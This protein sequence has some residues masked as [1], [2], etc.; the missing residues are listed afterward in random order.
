MT[1]VLKPFKY[2]MINTYIKLSFEN[3]QGAVQQVELPV[4]GLVAP[5]HKLVA[6]FKGNNFYELAREASLNAGLYPFLPAEPL[7][8]INLSEDLILEK[9]DGKNSNLK[10]TVNLKN[11]NVNIDLS[12]EG[13]W[14]GVPTSSL[15]VIKRQD[16]LQFEYSIDKYSF[17][18][19]GQTKKLGQFTLK[20]SDIKTPKSRHYFFIAASHTLFPQYIQVSDQKLVCSIGVQDYSDC[21]QGLDL[22]FGSIGLN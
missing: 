19:S 14:L 13:N 18:A 15:E 6:E 16:N 4:I 1:V 3:E 17:V 8:E 7:Q 21:E 20:L 2:G 10:P 9:N 11:E 22:D 12:V 5:K